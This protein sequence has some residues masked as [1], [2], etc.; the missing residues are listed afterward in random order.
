MSWAVPEAFS[1]V[2]S[3]SGTRYGRGATIES[4]YI[5]KVST[6]YTDVFIRTFA[7]RETLRLI[8]YGS[9]LSLAHMNSCLVWLLFHLVTCGFIF[10][11][12]VGGTP[13]LCSRN[14]RSSLSNTGPVGLVT[15]CE[16]LS[17]WGLGG[18]SQ[19]ARDRT[20]VEFLLF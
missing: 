12:G 7:G 14:P 16:G 9:S 15:L 1:A 18:G 8:W 4:G 3:V 13:K 5:I 19:S 2:V 17:L 20:K 11:G 10:I 6:L